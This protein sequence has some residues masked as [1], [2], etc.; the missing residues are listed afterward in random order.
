M[1]EVAHLKSIMERSDISESKQTEINE[2]RIY[3]TELNNQ[4][5]K[6]RIKSKN[7]ARN[8][9]DKHEGVIQNEERIRNMKQ[10]IRFKKIDQSNDTDDNREIDKSTVAYA[11]ERYQ[12]CVYQKEE[13]LIDQQS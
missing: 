5:K 6:L 1:K 12:L 9:L 2:L 10:I 8:V 13:Q 3:I 11:E 4:L 7:E